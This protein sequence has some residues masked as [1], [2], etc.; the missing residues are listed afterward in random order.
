MFKSNFRKCLTWKSD[1]TKLIYIFLS[2]FYNYPAHSIVDIERK[3]RKQKQKQNSDEKLFWSI[4]K[5][6]PACLLFLVTF[7]NYPAR[8]IVDKEKRKKEKKQNSDE[9]FSAVLS[10]QT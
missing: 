6:D 9:K 2:L 4:G 8:S 5:S 3:E 1:Q 7:Y 10:E